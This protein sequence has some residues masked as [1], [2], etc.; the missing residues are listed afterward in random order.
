MNLL[1]PLIVYTVIQSLS[2]SQT[3]QE[4]TR[5]ESIARD[6]IEVVS[7]EP[8]LYADDEDRIKTAAVMLAIIDYESHFS[9]DVDVGARKGD[10]GTS[11]C[12]AQ[13]N[14]GKG[15]IHVKED[16][17]VEFGTGWSGRDLVE[18]RTK[19]LRAELAVIRASF[20][21]KTE[22]KYAKLNLYASGKCE[23]GYRES[24]HRMKLAF[25]L[26]GQLASSEDEY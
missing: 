20:A 17:T 2:P 8:P 13:I 22:D 11:W 1:T 24:K 14:I 23:W 3:E 12:L 5:K 4:I 19:C 15:R 18:D 26:E 25:K 16:G 10:G 6:L 21:C 7:S 9:R